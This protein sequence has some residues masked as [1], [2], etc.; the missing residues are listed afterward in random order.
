MPGRVDEDLAEAVARRLHEGLGMARPVVVQL[1][2]TGLGLA[3]QIGADELQALAQQ[4]ADHAVGLIDV[5]RPRLAHG[6][7]LAQ[8]VAHQP[9]QLFARRRSPPGLDEV[10]LQ[11]GE[12]ALVDDY[13]LLGRRLAGQDGI[14]A[15]QQPAEQQEM[16][17]RLAQGTLQQRDASGAGRCSFHG[18]SPQ[19]V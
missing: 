18:L 1:L 19:S 13:L 6:H 5:Q 14:D 9:L 7:F 17:Q 12:A 8:I 10:A 2:V 4:P 15:E 11:R 16:Q 3:G